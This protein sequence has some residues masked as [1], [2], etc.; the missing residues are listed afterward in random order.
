MTYD[1]ADRGIGTDYPDD[2]ST[3]GT[4]LGA[5][6][7]PCKDPNCLVCCDDET[8]ARLTN[9]RTDNMMTLEADDD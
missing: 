6:D 7:A 5:Y 4:G 3:Y 9:A 8:F 2:C 1:S